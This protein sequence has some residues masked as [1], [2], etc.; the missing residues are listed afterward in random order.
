M[1]KKQFISCPYC[2]SQKIVKNGHH[3]KDKLQFFC[4]NCHKYF[5]EDPAKGYPPTSIPFPIIAYLLY[6]RQK[7]PEFSNMR[8]FR[9]FANHWVHHL[10]VSDQD[11]SRQTIHH[12]IK[13][14]NRLLDQVISFSEARDF[15]RQRNSEIHGIIPPIKPV[16]Y[17]RAL[18]I[19]TGKFGKIYCIDLIRR[20]PVF[21]QE[22]V[23]IVSKYNVFC[24]EL[25]DKDYLESSRSQ[26]SL[27][28][29]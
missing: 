24:W 1:E 22:L 10:K 16:S 28:V 6:F 26:H 21:F 15:F 17:K 3:H 25:L 12:W 29:G 18:K 4:T 13:N 23:D 9:K 27:S 8:K 14:Y 5:Y 19:L 7:I 11:V 20:D 2:N